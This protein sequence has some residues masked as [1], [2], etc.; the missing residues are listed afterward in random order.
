MP[1]HTSVPP[2]PTL[3]ST[4]GPNWSRTQHKPPLPAQ[5]CYLDRGDV[6]T[7]GDD[8]VLLPALAMARTPSNTL[9]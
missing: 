6:L 8:H 5:V 4:S 1:V 3:S 2:L 9:R 7:T